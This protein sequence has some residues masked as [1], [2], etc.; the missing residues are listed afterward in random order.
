MR[1]RVRNYH[2]TE[3][4]LSNIT[5]EKILVHECTACGAE[6]PEIPDLAKLHRCITVQILRKDT[7]LD[8]DEIRFL[9]KIAGLKASE[10]ASLM[11]T[12]PSSLSRWENNSKP[13]GKAFDRILRLI[14]YSGLLERLLRMQGE[15]LIDRTA[16]AA[17]VLPSLDIRN[18]LKNT[19]QKARAPKKMVTIDPQKL[20]GLGDGLDKLA[21]ETVQ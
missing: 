12:T 10:L 20:A 4:G 18:F 1:S 14:C 13:I 3:C 15:Q 19:G 16:V 21:T 17:H 11:R 2:Y 9:R 6:S 8:G 7:L 5:L